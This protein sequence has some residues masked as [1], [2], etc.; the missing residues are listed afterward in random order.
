MTICLQFSRRI[1][2]A[3]SIGPGAA[4]A[5]TS[6]SHL[7]LVVWWHSRNGVRTLWEN[8]R[9]VNMLTVHSPPPHAHTHTHTCMYMHPHPFPLYIL[10]EIKTSLGL[11]GF[12]RNFPPHDKYVHTSTPTARYGIVHQH[13]SGVYCCC[14]MLNHLLEEEMIISSMQSVLC[15]LWSVLIKRPVVAELCFFFVELN[16]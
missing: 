14:V 6:Q 1:Y 3:R 16:C 10:W 13:Y 5:W 7:L 8:L 4:H 15:F 11:P 2:C 12:Q 9:L